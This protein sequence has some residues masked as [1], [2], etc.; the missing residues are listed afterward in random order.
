M[1]PATSGQRPSI[2]VAATPAAAAPRVN[3]SSSAVLVSTPTTWSGRSRML[4]A[5]APT[6]TSS[7]VPP[8]ASAARATRS[9]GVSSVRAHASS[10][11]AANTLGSKKYGVTGAAATIASGMAQP[12]RSIVHRS[13]AG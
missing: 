6:P 4:A 2:G 10:A 3:A 5:P 12:A 8:P 11:A 7:T 13:L 9:D 1:S